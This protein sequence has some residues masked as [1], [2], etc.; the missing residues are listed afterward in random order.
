MKKIIYSFK[1]KSI[2]NVHG[3]EPKS[4]QEQTKLYHKSLVCLE[5]MTRGWIHT[6]LRD[7]LYMQ[8]VKQTTEN[9]SHA[10]LLL[11]WELITI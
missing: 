7:E 3:S 5:I 9:P 1:F 11:G 10:A 4:S 2:N 8:L 6:Q